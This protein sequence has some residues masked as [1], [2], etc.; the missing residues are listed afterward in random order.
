MSLLLIV[1]LLVLVLALVPDRWTRRALADERLHKAFWAA[2]VLFPIITHTLVYQSLPNE[3]FDPE[4]HIVLRYLEHCDRNGCQHGPS[5]WKNKQTG[6]IY[7]YERFAGHRQSEA[8]RIAVWTFAY[9]LIGCFAFAGFR[10][11]ETEPDF[12]KPFNAAVCV[13]AGVSGVM[14]LSII[15]MW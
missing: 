1:P 4:Q 2:F 9:G 3:D 5:V 12:W 6:E 14:F 10:K 11:R 7:S 13:N 8:Y 15:L